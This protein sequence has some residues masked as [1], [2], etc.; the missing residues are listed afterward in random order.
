[1]PL[2][3]QAQR[4]VDAM[5]ALNLKPVESS[6]PDEAR[7]S[8]RI[9]TSALGPFEDVRRWPTTGCPWREGRS[10]Y[11]RTRPEAPARIRSSSTTTAEAG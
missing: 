5:A 9:R 10:P 6:T 2:D 8:I 1:M 4:V 3:P 11:A 7:E